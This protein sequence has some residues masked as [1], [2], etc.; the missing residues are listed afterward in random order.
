VQ[1]LRSPILAAVLYGIPA[2]GVCQT[3]RHGARDGNTELLLLVTLRFGP[4]SSVFIIGNKC[5]C[6]IVKYVKSKGSLF[7]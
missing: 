4:H 6:Y 1:V 2:V 7:V 5:I 3:L